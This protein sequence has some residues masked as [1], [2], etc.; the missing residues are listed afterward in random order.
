MTNR[1]SNLFSIAGIAAALIVFTGQVPQTASA[2]EPAPTVAPVP[3]A[4]SQ[5]KAQ[6]I[7]KDLFKD[8]IDGAKN[9]AGKLD[10]AKTLLQKGD[11]TQGD[12]A[13]QYVLLKM[14]REYAV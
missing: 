8:Q 12:P 4:G 10:V 2:D 1:S 9:A 6:R 14:A 13:G 11:D 5:E 7:V 3:D